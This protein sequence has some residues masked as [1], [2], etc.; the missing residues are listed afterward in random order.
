M[1]KLITYVGWFNINKFS[2]DVNEAFQN[3]WKISKLSIEKKFLR[4]FCYALLFKKDDLDTSDSP[5]N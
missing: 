2:K 5:I 1:H 4:F 3:G